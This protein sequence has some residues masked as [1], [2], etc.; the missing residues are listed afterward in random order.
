MGYNS[1]RTKIQQTLTGR[2]SGTQVTPDSH[3]AMA[4]DVLNYIQEVE[5]ISL[6]GLEGIAYTDTTPVQPDKANCAYISAVPSNTTYTY[7]NFADENGDVVSITATT[8]P[9]FVI[10]FWNKK[11]WS[12]LA[13]TSAPHLHISAKLTD[14]NDEV[15][16]SKAV[17]DALAGKQNTLT[18]GTGISIKNGNTISCTVS[19]GNIIVDSTMSS[20]STNPVQNKVIY[21]ALQTLLDQTHKMVGI[22]E[23]DTLTDLT[24]ATTGTPSLYTVKTTARSREVK[25]G[26]LIV[27]T[28]N[29]IH[30][31]TQTLFTHYLL[32]E[33]GGIDTGA[34][35][36]K[37]HIYNRYYRLQK[38]NDEVGTWT[39]WNSV[40][41]ADVVD[42]IDVIY[43]ALQNKQDKINYETWTFTTVSGTTVTKKVYIA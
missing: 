12:Y 20:T 32:T 19:G 29:L 39:T 33:A 4:E 22:E 27:F 11:Y 38:E 25:V 15:P 9:L 36:H 6:S 2:T 10:L 40:G 8:D 24:V 18:A 23:L 5:N 14:S 3:Q 16:S 28:D 42:R 41:G 34:H 26:L 35:D 30:T 31:I 7:K 43:T 37:L 13:T 17:S 1:S 21:S